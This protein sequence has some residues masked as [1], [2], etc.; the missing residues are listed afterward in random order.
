MVGLHFIDS[1]NVCF[2]VRF[3]IAERNLPFNKQASLFDDIK[4]VGKFSYHN[5]PS[6]LITIFIRP[7]YAVGSSS[8]FSYLFV[9]LCL[10]DPMLSLCFLSTGFLS[11][12]KL[13]T[14]SVATTSCLSTL[15][16]R[17]HVIHFVYKLFKRLGNHLGLVFHSNLV[18]RIKTNYFT[19]GKNFSEMTLTFP[20]KRE[21]V[22]SLHSG[23]AEQDEVKQIRYRNGFLPICFQRKPAIQ[24]L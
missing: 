16:M 22:G 9:L 17:I 24:I 14:L 2:H 15:L 20:N 23:T 1:S 10:S 12:L 8:P 5:M 21:R 19:H 7:M 11:D 3:V 4:C 13:K 18:L 6:M